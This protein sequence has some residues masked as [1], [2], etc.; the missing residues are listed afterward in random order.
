[1]GSGSSKSAAPQSSASALADAPA[2]TSQS[3]AVVSRRDEAIGI[4]IDGLVLYGMFVTSKYIY[5]VS[6]QANRASTAM[7]ETS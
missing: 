3:N 7:Y 2:G 6:M 5:K 4:L 1:M